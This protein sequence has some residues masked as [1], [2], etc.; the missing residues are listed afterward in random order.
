MVDK[1]IEYLNEFYLSFTND[2]CF[3]DIQKFLTTQVNY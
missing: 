3:F 1:S 2:N